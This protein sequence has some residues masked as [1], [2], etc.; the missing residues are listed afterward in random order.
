MPQND[1]FAMLNFKP[2]TSANEVKSKLNES[3]KR[4]EASRKYEPSRVLP[5]YP[6]LRQKIILIQNLAKQGRLEKRD[7]YN[8]ITDKDTLYKVMQRIKEQ[9]WFP[10]DTETDN[11]DPQVAK[12][13]G[14]SFR[15][16]EAQKEY[17]VPMLHCDTQKNIL[18][19]QLTYEEVAEIMEEVFTSP[20]I[21]KITQNGVYDI[22]VIKNNLKLD[23]KGVYWDTLLGMRFIDFDHRGN[24]LKQLYDEFILG[25]KGHSESYESLFNEI[26]FCFV[27]IDIAYLYA[28]KDALMTDEVCQWQI[29]KL[30]QMLDERTMKHIFEIEMKQI[31]VVA[32]MENRGIMISKENANV[33]YQEYKELMDEQK[34]K[35]DNFFFEY[36]GIKDINYNSP[37]QVSHL[38]YDVMKCESVDKKNP[39]G[40]GEEIIQKLVNKNPNLSILQELLNYRGTQ[41]LISTYLEAIP[42]QADKDNIIRARFNPYGAKTGRYS[43]SNPNMQNIPAHKNKA[44][45]KDDSRIRWM[46]VP[47][48]G[49]VFLSVDYSQIEPRLLAYR[50]NDYFMLE[51]YNSGK[52]LYASMAASVYNMTYEQCLED[53]EPGGKER[54]SSVKSLLLGL[55]YGRQK[56]SIAEQLGITVAEAERFIETFFNMFPSIKEYMDDTI[57]MGTLLGYVTTIYG[58]KVFYPDLS[59]PNDYVRQEAQRQAI[60]CTIQGSSAEITKRAMWFIHNDEFLQKNDAHLIL[61]IHDEVVV[62]CPKDRIYEVG[63]RVRDLMI[64]GA[65]ILLEKMPVKCDVEVFEEAWAKDGYKLKFD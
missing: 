11:T 4:V 19:G 8:I 33:L 25:E 55:M 63:K 30:K 21:K 34:A 45:G 48:P 6:I 58:R 57:R 53:Y 54:R 44:T 20:D 27:P 61:T 36:Y 5:Q 10:W 17:Y 43:S 13:V 32:N 47:R 40:T 15:D 28:C 62:E 12:L 50:S 59:H 9:K 2:K 52:D 24:S 41:K 49:Y 39:R 29:N 16:R 23:V 3:I 18:E 64:K 14:L 51:A 31:E 42:Q 22:R 37:Q 35:L 1:L 56:W 65:E 7:S 26:P 38:I 60:N 46:F